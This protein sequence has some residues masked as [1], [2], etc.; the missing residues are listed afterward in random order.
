MIEW[1]ALF[2]SDRRLIWEQNVNS[3]QPSINVALFAP[4]DSELREHRKT[5]LVIAVAVSEFK[6]RKS[7][8][9]SGS[10]ARSESIR[11]LWTHDKR[12]RSAVQTLRTATHPRHDFL[13]DLSLFRAAARWFL[14]TAEVSIAEHS[15]DY[16]ESGE[17]AETNK[18]SEKFFFLAF[19]VCAEQI[20][21]SMMIYTSFRFAFASFALGSSHCEATIERV[22]LTLKHFNPSLNWRN[23]PASH[24]TNGKTTMTGALGDVGTRSGDDV[25]SSARDDAKLIPR[26][27]AAWAEASVKWRQSSLGVEW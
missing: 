5:R 13:I 19:C 1:M 7:V 22:D 16:N 11:E 18:K 17:R 3:W 24:P 12:S 27:T 26:L 9:S 20:E 25:A 10:C 21:M 23:I 4:I 14:M 15:S 6:A 2:A 8:S